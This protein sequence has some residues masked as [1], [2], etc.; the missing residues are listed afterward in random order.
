MELKDNITSK[1]GVYVKE[2]SR[3]TGVF[4]FLYLGRF[5]FSIQDA[6]EPSQKFCSELFH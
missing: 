2:G 4:F 1:K 6:R 3:N 5:M